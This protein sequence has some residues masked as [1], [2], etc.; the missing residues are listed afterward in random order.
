MKTETETPAL[1]VRTPEAI[2]QAMDKDSV[3]SDPNLLAQLNAELSVSLS[4]VADKV[5]RRNLSIA[6]ISCVVAVIALLIS[7][8]QVATSLCR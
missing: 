8:I 2:L 7:L 3:R 1:P 4:I 5:S 6:T